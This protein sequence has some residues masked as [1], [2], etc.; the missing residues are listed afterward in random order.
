MYTKN[1]NSPYYLALQGIS[2]NKTRLNI[3]PKVF[4]FKN[5]GSSNGCIIDSGTLYSRIISPAFD[6]LNKR[7]ESNFR[8]SRTWRESKAI[9]AWNYATKGASLKGL[10]SYLVL[11]SIS[12]DRTQILLWRLRQC[13]RLFVPS[14]FVNTFVWRWWGILDVHCWKSSANKS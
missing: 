7:W 5:N 9:W 3:N 13:L 14:G 12:G 6:I 2:L 8:D 11:L 10:I 4:A 1:E